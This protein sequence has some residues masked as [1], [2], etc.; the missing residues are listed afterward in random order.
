MRIKYAFELNK[1]L[2]DGVNKNAMAHLAIS[3]IWY[4]ASQSLLLLPFHYYYT[5]PPL[6]LRHPAHPKLRRK[7]KASLTLGASASSLSVEFYYAILIE[8]AGCP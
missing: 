8:A 3:N 6:P 5:T 7:L 4:V 1:F 2:A